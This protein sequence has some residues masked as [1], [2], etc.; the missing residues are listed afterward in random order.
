MKYL[1]SPRQSA[2]KRASSTS[3]GEPGAKKV[4]KQFVQYPAIR[5]PVLPVGEDDISYKRNQRLLLSEEKNLNPNRKTVSVLMDRTFPF[6]RQD[7][8]KNSY[9]I[10]EVL[11]KFP[12]LRR[13]DQVHIL[14]R[15][16][17]NRYY[18]RTSTL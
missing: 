7:L 10:I 5:E 16:K 13:K 17:I 1:R 8:L 4:R 9:P 14:I 6:R 2:A 12:S 18:A 15:F 11:K 3:E